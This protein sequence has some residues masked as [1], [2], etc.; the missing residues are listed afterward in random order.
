MLWFLFITGS[1]FLHCVIERNLIFVAC[2]ISWKNRLCYLYLLSKGLET[3][4]KTMA[5]SRAIK[6][7][8]GKPLDTVKNWPDVCSRSVGR[9]LSLF[10][11]FKF[12]GI[13]V[14][15]K[16]SFTGDG[17]ESV[18]S[19]LR[20]G[21]DHRCLIFP[22]LNWKIQINSSAW[23]GCFRENCHHRDSIADRI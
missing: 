8:L 23:T 17:K 13:D 9:S 3:N 1:L 19:L 11:L 6:L 7:S 20:P 2:S 22:F 12:I 16:A 4:F 18:S 5:M 14:K 21:L 15:Y 10:C